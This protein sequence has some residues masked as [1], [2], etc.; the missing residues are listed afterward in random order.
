MS[1]PL[2]TAAQTSIRCAAQVGV[3]RCLIDVAAGME[4]LHSLG[5]IHGD[6]KGANV[7]LKSTA[8]DPRGFTCKVVLALLSQPYPT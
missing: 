5:V 7:L 2:S 8:S 4:Y 3:L 1:P 6:L